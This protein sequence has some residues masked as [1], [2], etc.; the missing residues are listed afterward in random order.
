MLLHE[1]EMTRMAHLWE[2]HRSDCKHE[3]D[4]KIEYGPGGGIG[5][6]VKVTCGCGKVM[7]VTD[8]HSW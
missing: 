4:A 8:Y 5:T 7:D 6:T 1:K 2:Y 3:G